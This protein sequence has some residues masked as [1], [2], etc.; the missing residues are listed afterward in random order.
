MMCVMVPYDIR[1]PEKSEIQDSELE[2]ASDF[3][4]VF[5][6]CPLLPEQAVGWAGCTRAPAVQITVWQIKMTEVAI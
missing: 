1:G 4:R 5:A 2:S 6:V 3:V